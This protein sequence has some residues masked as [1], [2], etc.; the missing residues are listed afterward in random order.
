MA[1]PGATLSPLKLRALPRVPGLA[2][3]K[4]TRYD[5]IHD[6]DAFIFNLNGTLVNTDE[7]LYAALCKAFQEVRQ[8]P[9]PVNYAEWT[10]ANHSRRSPCGTIADLFKKH[11]INAHQVKLLMDAQNAAYDNFLKTK[12]ALNP[13]AQEVLFAIRNTGKPVAIVTEGQ[14]EEVMKIRDQF[15]QLR[16]VPNEHWFF[17]SKRKHNAYAAAFAMLRSL[18]HGVSSRPS[19]STK[20]ILRKQ[21]DEAGRS[22]RVSF[23]TTTVS[24][25]SRCCCFV[26]T[27]SAATD[28]LGTGITRVFWLTKDIP[29]QDQFREDA[30]YPERLSSRRLVRLRSLQTVGEWGF[31]NLPPARLSDLMT[32]RPRTSG[33][34][35]DRPLSDN[36]APATGGPLTDRPSI[37]RPGTASVFSTSLTALSPDRPGTASLAPLASSPISTG[38]SP[39]LRPLAPSLADRAGHSPLGGLSPLTPP[40]NGLSP[41][42]PPNPKAS[43]LTRAP[44]LTDRPITTAAVRPGTAALGDRLASLDAVAAVRPATAAH[45]PPLSSSGSFRLASQASSNGAVGS[46]RPPA[47]PKTGGS[48]SPRSRPPMLKSRALSFSMLDTKELSVDGIVVPKVEVHGIRQRGMFNRTA[49]LQRISVTPITTED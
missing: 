38:L 29:Y 18:I 19:T 32:D 44:S 48:T 25:S 14:E 41:I 3:P 22:P 13:G 27:P 26:D 37:D 33:A 45:P 49:S 24:L 10:L 39:S 11:G 4:S 28:V 47:S 23:D 30:V 6:W 7:L 34:F 43:P 16:A 42:P 15:A 31:A 5:W 46:P 40:T 2:L 20:G 17:H 36:H 1:L 21:G 9:C 35:T 12:L 8:K